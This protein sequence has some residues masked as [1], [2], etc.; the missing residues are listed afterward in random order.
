MRLLLSD[1]GDPECVVHVDE[2]FV[3]QIDL[4]KTVLYVPVAWED[5]PTYNKCLEWFVKTYQHY[6]ALCLRPF[7]QEGSNHFQDF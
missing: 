5:G 6:L 7:C 1:G 3:S 4:H 2:F